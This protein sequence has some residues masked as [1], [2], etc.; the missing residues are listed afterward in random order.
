M[1]SIFRQFVKICRKT[2]NRYEIYY[3]APCGR[4]LGTIEDVFKYLL[5]TES[6]L[7]IDCFSFEL[8][9][10]VTHEWE[11]FKKIVDIEVRK[12][13]GCHNYLCWKKNKI[14]KNGSQH[15]L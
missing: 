6:N 3:S 5:M 12:R 13:L 15:C 7:E 11:P 9:V 14:K 2:V 4:R 10:M 1:L 8:S